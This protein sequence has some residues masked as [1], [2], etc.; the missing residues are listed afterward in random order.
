MPTTSNRAKLGRPPRALYVTEA[1]VARAPADDLL[2]AFDLIADEI[3]RRV[4]NYVETGTTPAVLL[5]GLKFAKRAREITNRLMFRGPINILHPSSGYA[6]HN[7]ETTL[8]G[9]MAKLDGDALDSD[10]YS[11]VPDALGGDDDV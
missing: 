2:G 10:L 5:D 7:A 11:R 6:L 8:V 1:A 4:A 3:L 9:A